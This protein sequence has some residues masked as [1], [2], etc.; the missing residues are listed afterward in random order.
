MKPELPE[1]P[2]DALLDHNGYFQQLFP[3]EMVLQ[4]GENMAVF[5]RA[6]I[7]DVLDAFCLQCEEQAKSMRESGIS[8]CFRLNAQLDTV[9]LLKEAIARR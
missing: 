2:L 9:R 1:S 8:D 4:Y 3:E 5:E 6:R 7:I